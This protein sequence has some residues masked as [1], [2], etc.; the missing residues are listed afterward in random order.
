MAT[1]RTNFTASSEAIAGV[2]GEF[3]MLTL[4]KSS[5][6]TTLA[7]TVGIATGMVLSA[8]IARS[9]Q[10]DAQ[11]AVTLEPE[12]TCYVDFMKLIKDD[13]VLLSKQIEIYQD[14]QADQ[15][16]EYEG[17]VKRMSALGKQ[18]DVLQANDRKY[19]ETTEGMI[20]EE[21]RWSKSKIQAEL[22]LQ[23]DVAKEAKIRFQQIRGYALDIAKQR[24]ATQV[25]VI[26][27]TPADSLDFSEL[28]KQMMLTPVLYWN[29][30][31][32]ITDD[33]EKRAKLDMDNSECDEAFAVDEKG[34]KRAKLAEDKEKNPERIDYEVALKGTLSLRGKF[35]D[36]D[37][38]A[39]KRIDMESVNARPIWDLRGFGV[40][41]ILPAPDGSAT[42]TAPE[43][44]PSSADKEKGAVVEIEV[45]PE[46]SRSKG[47]VLRIRLLPPPKENK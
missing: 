41:T 35:S 27:R 24:G 18:R 17:Y 46:K 31:Y 15:R 36:L 26:S 13:V 39:G 4:W 8:M 20:E 10:A 43:V 34:A 32:D 11:A 14:I 1:S 19:R 23:S 21:A 3:R 28:Q 47:K 42:Y 12:K 7:L 2:I 22:A 29:P 33:V 9:S 37:K 30:A 45:A 6:V 5:L 16:K 40:G 44:L 25:L 38:A